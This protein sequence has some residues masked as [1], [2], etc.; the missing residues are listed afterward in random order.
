MLGMYANRRDNLINKK[1]IKIFKKNGQFDLDRCEI[2]FIVGYTT[3]LS[4]FTLL[5]WSVCIYFIIRQL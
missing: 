5:I 1:I 4:I 2:E 3:I